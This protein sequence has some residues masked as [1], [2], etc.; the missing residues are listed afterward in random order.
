MQCRAPGIISEDDLLRYTLD[1]QDLSSEASQ[2]FDI[3]PLCRARADEY[4][5][6]SSTLARRLHRWDCP[7]TL[8]ISEYAAGLLTDKERKKL[9]AHLKHCTHCSEE[10]AISQ[11]FLGTPEPALPQR[12]RIK[13]TLVQQHHLLEAQRA[14]SVRGDNPWPRQYTVD[15]ISLSLHLA[16]PSPPGRGTALI[17]LISRLDIS[18]ATLEDV[19]VHLLP[20]SITDQQVPP[21][22]KIKLNNFMFQDIPPGS[23]EL[24]IALPEGNVLIEDLELRL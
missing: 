14:M 10:V 4:K 16:P 8:E 9:E 11:E 12:P 15:G 13:A 18:Q 17:G 6:M 7:T 1:P 2:H 20:T 24:L 23:Y 22:V 21:A 19:E 3:C 5:T